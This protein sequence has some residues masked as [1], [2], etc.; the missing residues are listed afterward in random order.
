MILLPRLEVHEIDLV[1][2][3]LNHLAPEPAPDLSRRVVEQLGLHPHWNRS[4]GTQAS[5]G[6]RSQLVEQLHRIAVEQ[7]Y[8]EAPGLARQQAFDR[9][10][11]RRL[12]ET[13]ILQ[14]AGGELYRASCWAGLVVF[15]MLDLVLWRHGVGN[16]KLSRD[17]L[18]GGN[19]NF[20]RRLWLRVDAMLLEPGAN[21]DRWILVD[22]L[23]ED[24]LVQI[25]ERPSIASCPPLAR[26][27]G[28]VWMQLSDE[29][30]NMEQ[31]MRLATRRLRA[32]NETLALACLDTSTLVAEVRK[33]F[34]QAVEILQG[35]RQNA[36][37]SVVGGSRRRGGDTG[38][39]TTCLLSSPDS[40]RS[41]S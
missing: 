11:C 35:N 30:H 22:G 12:R 8:P 23:T 27:I 13:E 15:D 41:S 39:S 14:K 18:L 19:R 6:L 37:Q 16:R 31:I 24:A 29:H 9:E 3:E 21:T 1:L 10:A 2:A 33:A 34:A 38:I 5:S 25:I 17:R 32:R 20:L 28:L 26:A 40:S 7:G 36:F 4:G